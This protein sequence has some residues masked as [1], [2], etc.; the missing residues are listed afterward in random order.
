MRILAGIFGVIVTLISA[1]FVVMAIGDLIFGSKTQTSVLL[2]LLVF[3][4][5]TGLAGAFLAKFGFRKKEAGS[6]LSDF[7][8]EQRILSYASAC[9]G[10][11]TVPNVSLHCHL[12]LAETQSM[13]DAM[14]HTGAAELRVNDDGSF[15]YLF[16][17]FLRSGPTQPQPGQP[18]AQPYNPYQLNQAPQAEPPQRPPGMHERQG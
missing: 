5:G 10:V 7:E 13:L 3:F 12:S 1:M 18:V 11:V 15:C 6:Q 8:K 9:G 2:G 16:R 4:G 17:G 14:T